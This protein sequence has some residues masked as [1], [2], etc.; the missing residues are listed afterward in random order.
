MQESEDKKTEA[1]D[2]KSPI[3]S[4]QDLKEQAELFREL[5]KAEPQKIF[6]RPLPA[7]KKYLYLSLI[8]AVLCLVVFLLIADRSRRQL[9]ASAGE[10]W[11]RISGA[12][13]NEIFRLPPPPPQ[14]VRTRVLIS[15]DTVASADDE[16]QPMGVL[17][18][19]QTLSSPE[20]NEQTAAPVVL[21]HNPLNEAAYNLLRETEEVTGE[22]GENNHPE[23]E[24]KGW[25]SVKDDAPEFWIDLVVTRRSDGQEVHLIWSVNT[26]TNRI[27]A[28]SQAARDLDASR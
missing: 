5:A 25:R 17:F 18:W 13:Q 9:I 14:A 10:G 6:E 21:A 7:W 19:N 28:L 3:V 22:L 4:S 24:F 23:F 20:R 8:F 15:G 16:E 26:E 27:T 12:E 11:N 1:E 2:C